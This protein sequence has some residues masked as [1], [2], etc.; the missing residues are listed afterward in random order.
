LISFQSNHSP[1][2]DCFLLWSHYCLC[3]CSSYINPLKTGLQFPVGR[4]HR[5]WRKEIGLCTVP[6]IDGYTVLCDSHGTRTVKGIS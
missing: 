2:I 1:L 4:V 5:S 6:Y 3:C